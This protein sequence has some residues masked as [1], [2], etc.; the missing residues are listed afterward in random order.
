MTTP[1][2]DTKALRARK[3]QPIDRIRDAFSRA[4]KM[5]TGVWAPY[6]S[7]PAD[8]ERDADLILSDAI[9]ELE[10]LRNAAPALLDLAE[11]AQE[12]ETDLRVVSPIFKALEAE[13][14]A[15][16]AEVAALKADH[17]PHYCAADHAQIQHWQSTDPEE[18]ACP[19]C[20]E[21]NAKENFEDK[22][23]A[24]AAK[25]SASEREAERLTA[26]REDLLKSRDR[27]IAERNEQSGLRDK[28]IERL[29]ASD[30][31]WSEALGNER[32][33]RD[34]SEREAER[35]RQLL[36]ASH[37]RSTGYS[38]KCDDCAALRGEE[39]KP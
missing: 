21:R 28:L 23:I 39:A 6:M 25:L 24:V 31:T 3:Q 29:T 22:Y 5:A 4:H 8:P 16:K 33:L 1:N 13:R 32:K 12:L 2:I 36:F 14:D 35:L 9:D 38:C 34:A 11:R 27:V 10:A 37:G 30:E 15:L 20:A 26:E 19:V 17:A 18:L 7:V